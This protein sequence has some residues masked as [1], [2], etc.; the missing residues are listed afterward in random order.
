MSFAELYTAL[1]QGVVDGQENPLQNIWSSNLAEVQQYLAVTRHIY[2]V[3][4]VI[5]AERFWQ[6]LGIDDREVLRQSLAASTRW[7]LEYMTRLDVELEARLKQEGMQ[8][9]YPDRR[10]FERAVQPAYAAILEQLGPDAERLVEQIR[11]L[12]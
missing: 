3:A 7:Q 1:A 5:V 11:Q 8:F 10:Q 2:N 12:K 9:T 6:S 4:Y